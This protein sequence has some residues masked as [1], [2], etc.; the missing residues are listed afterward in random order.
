MERGDR[1]RRGERATLLHGACPCY[2]GVTSWY[3]SLTTLPSPFLALPPLSSHRFASLERACT[4]LLVSRNFLTQQFSPFRKLEYPNTVP[5]LEFPICR[6]CIKLLL[7]RY[8]GSRIRGV[9]SAF[10]TFDDN[11]S[12]L[13]ISIDV[14]FTWAFGR[15]FRGWIEERCRFVGSLVTRI[16]ID[17]SKWKLEQK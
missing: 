13:M 12:M 5:L 16:S 6:I 3:T 17:A 10:Y 1:K 14:Y 8:R 2:Q 15:N 7:I 11:V 9:A 4:L